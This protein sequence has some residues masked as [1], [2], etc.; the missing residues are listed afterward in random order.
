[1]NNP[2][3]S[4]VSGNYNYS[5]GGMTAC[6]GCGKDIHIS[7][8]HCPSCGAS[9]RNRS[10]KSKG[11]AAAMSFLIGGFG[12]HRFYLGQWW[13]LFYLLFVWTWIPG[14]ISIIE[15]IVFLATDQRNWDDKYNEGKAA[16]PGEGAGGGAI[17]LVIIGVFFAVAIVGIL[18]A[19]AIPAYQDYTVRAKVASALTETAT[20][21]QAATEYILTYNEHPL[22]N[23][24]LNM[25]QPLL[26]REGH[27][28]DVYAG[29]I[30]VTFTGMAL[31]NDK[32]IILTPVKS[33]RGIDWDCRGGTLE[34]K[35]RPATCR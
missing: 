16:A 25:E 20:V 13:G 9:Q 7:A 19:I 27:K 14:I 33:Q 10:Y 15:S 29:G 2:Y 18:A 31:L 12:V 1:M 21:R 23:T 6:R 34:K 28:V 30:E 11:L 3:Q 17:A 32:T 24:A 22:N 4:P 8:A 26:L 5:E 35:Y